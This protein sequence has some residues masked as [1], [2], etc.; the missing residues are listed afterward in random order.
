MRGTIKIDENRCKGCEL[1]TSVCPKD[2]I[3]MATYFTPRGYHP[4]TLVD[5]QGA[6]TGCLLCSTI[7]PDAAITVYREADRRKKQGDRPALALAGVA[8]GERY[9]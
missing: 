7:C 9:E 8:G 5:P 3:S 1:C 6:C 4:A 2:L